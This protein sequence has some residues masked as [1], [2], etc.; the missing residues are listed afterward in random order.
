M[1]HLEAPFFFF[2]SF[3]KLWVDVIAHESEGLIMLGRSRHS[4]GCRYYASFP[5]AALP[6]HAVPEQQP[7]PTPRA[8]QPCAAP[9]PALPPGSVCWGCPAWGCHGWPCGIPSLRAGARCLA[10]LRGLTDVSSLRKQPA[11]HRAL[12]RCSPSSSNPTEPSPRGK[13]SWKEGLKLSNGET[14]ERGALEALLFREWE[15]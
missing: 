10:W 12:R 4:V 2:L 3:R 8:A 11:C 15:C 5:H 1:Y 14:S 9:C 6:V 7:Q 13:R